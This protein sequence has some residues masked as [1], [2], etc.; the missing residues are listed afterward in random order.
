MAMRTNL[1]FSPFFRS[2][3]GFDR[4]F[5]LLEDASRVA[6]ASNLAYDIL[7]VGEDGYRITLAVPGF[8]IENLEISQDGNALVVRGNV[9]DRDAQGDVLHQGIRT[10]SFTQRFELADYVNVTGA[11]LSEGLLS[12][13]LEREVPESMKPRRITIGQPSGDQPQR[14]IEAQVA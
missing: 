14:Q 5:D 10:R 11:N 6:H 3:I 8:S 9:G 7:K 12:I 13:D 2:S 4:V 1:D